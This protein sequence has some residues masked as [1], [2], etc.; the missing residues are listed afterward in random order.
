MTIEF[1]KYQ[2]TG[3]DFILIDNMEGHITALS[4]KTIH[5]FC[6]RHF[7]I[8]A[9]GLIV[10]EKSQV[11]SFYMK[12]YNAD[13]NESSLCGNGSRC[14]IQFAYRHSWIGI[15]AQFE[16]FDGVHEAKILKDQRICIAFNDTDQLEKY[17]DAI[18]CDSGS[19]HYIKVVDNI[20]TLDFIPLAKSIRYNSRFKSKGINVNYIQPLSL[21]EFAIRTYERG[22]ENETLACGTGVVA[23]ALSANFLGLTKANE[24]LFQTKGGPLEVHFKKEKSNYKQISLIGPAREVFKGYIN[25]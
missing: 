11:A 2:G 8:G 17:G 10:L 13:G 1:F 21:N 25:F 24:L 22:V 18:L 3:N 23:S 5:H 15:D 12:Y 16:A 4:R 7:G 9:D 20:E 6:N 14:A 19:P